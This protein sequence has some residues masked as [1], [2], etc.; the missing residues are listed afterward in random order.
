MV[1]S[2]FKTDTL[3][4]HS[5][6]C[7]HSLVLI[8]LC[9]LPCAPNLFV[10]PIRLPP[11]FSQLIQLLIH[12]LIRSLTHSFIHH[13]N[14]LKLPTHSPTHSVTPHPLTLIH[15]LTRSPLTHSLTH[16]PGHPSPTHSHSPTLLTRSPL[17]HSH[18]H[19]PFIHTLTTHSSPTHSLTLLP[20]THSHTPHPFT[21]SPTHSIA[22][23]S[24]TH[25]RTRSLRHAPILLFNPATHPRFLHRTLLFTQLITHSHTHSLSLPHKDRLL[26]RHLCLNLYPCVIK[27]QSVSQS[28]PLTLSGTHPAN[29]SPAP[30]TAVSTHSP[31][32]TRRFMIHIYYY[33]SDILSKDN[34]SFF[35]AFMEFSQK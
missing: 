9:S 17:T 8:P 26:D 13:F 29:H 2:A 18:T 24:P 32:Q 12:S 34:V 16:S 5:L 20:L 33:K 7:A 27:V 22:H 25:S 6:H 4:S 3:L 28:V 30:P 21:H 19:S 15:P 23:F 35:L 14:L 10:I 1:D 11:D 31:T